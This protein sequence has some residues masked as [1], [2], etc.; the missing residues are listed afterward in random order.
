M[1]V[2]LG[3]TCNNSTWRD[4]LIPTLLAKKI[5]YFNPIVENWTP[6][7][8]KKEDKEKALCDIHLYVITPKMTGVFSIAEVTQDSIKL[9]RGDTILII[10]TEDDDLTFSNSQLMSLDAVCKLVNSNGGVVFDNF[11][12]IVRYLVKRNVI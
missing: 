3:G 9:P 2:F 11:D 12:G 5:D 7:D 1:K 8:Q 4:K 6:E 10:L